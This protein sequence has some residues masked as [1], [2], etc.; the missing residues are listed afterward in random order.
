MVFENKKVM[1]QTV[2]FTKLA[3][4]GSGWVGGVAAGEFISSL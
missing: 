3:F 1:V 2:W 4:L